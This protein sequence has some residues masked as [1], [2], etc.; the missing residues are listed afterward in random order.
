MTEETQAGGERRRGFGHIIVC[1]PCDNTGAQSH[2]FTSYADAQYTRAWRAWIQRPCLRNI[3]RHD[4]IQTW[5]VLHRAWN[6]S[7]ALDTTCCLAHFLILSA[8]SEQE[9]TV[10][11]ISR[12]ATRDKA[13]SVR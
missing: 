2:T 9:H 7:A 8:T 11:P 4:T 1:H 10:Q 3:C 5:L 13:L 12:A 6:I